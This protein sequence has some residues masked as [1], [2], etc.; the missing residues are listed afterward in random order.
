MITWWV[1]FFFRMLSYDI[2]LRYLL[3]WVICLY[4]C[5]T[6]KMS[7]VIYIEL[8]EENCYNC[9]STQDPVLNLV[10]NVT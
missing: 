7:T 2:E 5:I 6:T 10:S 9:I 4:Q 8:E 1:R 3:Y